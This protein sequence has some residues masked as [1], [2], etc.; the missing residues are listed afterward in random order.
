VKA[1]RARQSGGR[2]LLLAD[3]RISYK[4]LAWKEQI[5]ESKLAVVLS[6]GGSKGAFQ[7]G[8]LDALINVHKVDFQI[9]A[10]VSTGAIQALAGAMD[11]V[12]GLVNY[13]TSITSSDDIYIEGDQA[14]SL[15]DATPLRQKLEAYCD[16]EKL[17]QTGKRL[18][19]GS[20]CFQDGNFELIT[21]SSMPVPGVKLADWIYASCVVPYIFPP[22]EVTTP[23]G[24]LLQWFD[25][26]VR[27]VTPLAAA[28][29]EQPSAI[30]II[31]ASTAPHVVKSPRRYMGLTFVGLRAI[32]ILSA[33]VSANDYQSAGMINDV[34]TAQKTITAALIDAGLGDQAAELLRPLTDVT[35]RYKYVP[36]YLIEPDRDYS[37]T[38][39]F[40]PEKIRA[41]IEGGRNYVDGPDGKWDEISAFIDS[42]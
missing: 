9:F 23:E 21:E 31:R 15:F 16:E 1:K 6:G 41:A 14:I 12:P 8:V 17:R 35:T 26:G 28:M 19:V 3:A 22:L 32:D 7:V 24:K 13:W 36:I 39:E 10:G 2:G 42:A 30:I 34:L 25:G 37:N 18:L 27:N 5:M 33:E 20:V 40:D 11:D 38:N 4:F 29:D